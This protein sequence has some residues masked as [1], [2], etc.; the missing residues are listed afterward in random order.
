MILQDNQHSYRQ[1]P[2]TLPDNKWGQLYIAVL[3]HQGESLRHK[4]CI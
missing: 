1:P 2:C 4:Q 3:V